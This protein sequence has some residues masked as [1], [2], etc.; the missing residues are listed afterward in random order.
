[1]KTVWGNGVEE[2]GDRIKTTGQP[3]RSLHLAPVL[4]YKL[5]KK[6]LHL[7]QYVPLTILQWFVLFIL[8]MI[9]NCMKSLKNI[10]KT[11]LIIIN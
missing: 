4:L 10:T 2:R 9:L 11:N 5:N 3:D 8:T 1:M 6:Q 7:S